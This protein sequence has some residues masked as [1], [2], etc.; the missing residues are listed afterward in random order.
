MTT[1]RPWFFPRKGEV[2]IGTVGVF[3]SRDIVG[4]EGRSGSFI[5]WVR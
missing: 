3:Y 1:T 2:W 4:I 5:G